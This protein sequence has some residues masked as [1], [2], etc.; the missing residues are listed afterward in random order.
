MPAN[1]Y[2]F[3]EQWTIPGSTQEQVYEVLANASIVQDGWPGV[4]LAE[5]FA[6]VTDLRNE[7]RW[8]PEIRSVTQEGP[9]ASGATFR[10]SRVS[11]GRS[12][13]SRLSRSSSPSD[14]CESPMRG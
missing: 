11:F 10:E 12:P 4:H 7:T 13:S 5:V 1:T 8:Q 6:F 14:L 2:H 9:L 3:R